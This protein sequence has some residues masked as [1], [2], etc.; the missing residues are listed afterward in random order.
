MDRKYNIKDI[1]EKVASVLNG[2]S[3]LFGSFLEYGSKKTAESI[4]EKLHKEGVS[5]YAKK[6]PYKKSLYFVVFTDIETLQNSGKGVQ[7]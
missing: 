6:S 5:C 7:L 3:P 4:V 2:D 1:K